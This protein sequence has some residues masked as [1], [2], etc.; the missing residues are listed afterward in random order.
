MT[1]STTSASKAKAVGA[2]ERRGIVVSS[3]QARRSASGTRF[4]EAARRSA[5]GTVR[6][7]MKR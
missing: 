2:V 3:G 6:S 1:K 4:P 7:A 5:Q